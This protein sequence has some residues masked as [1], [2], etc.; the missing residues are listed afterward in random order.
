MLRLPTLTEFNFSF[1]YTWL[2]YSS[3]FVCLIGQAWTAEW[4]DNWTSPTTERR[5]DSC[6]YVIND[7]SRRSANQTSS[8]R[9]QHSHYYHHH[10]QSPPFRGLSWHLSSTTEKTRSN[11]SGLNPHS[12]QDRTPSYHRR[13]VR[14]DPP[15]T[16]LHALNRQA[17]FYTMF[18]LSWCK[19]LSAVYRR[20][21]GENQVIKF[22]TY[23]QDQDIS[24][25]PLFQQTR[26]LSKKNRGE[27]GS[28]LEGLRGY[29]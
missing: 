8:T 2:F 29:L 14:T 5:T 20:P 1:S 21:L 26:L 3:G 23:S 15:K 24:Q 18:M 11:A 19:Y 17:S 10:L 12:P 4:L 7:V 9:Q 13:R 28:V 27:G 6:H 16:D 22:C 25:H